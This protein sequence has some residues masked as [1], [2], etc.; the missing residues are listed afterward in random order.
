MNKKIFDILG[1]NRWHELGY[2]GKGVTVAQLELTEGIENPLNIPIYENYPSHSYK[3]WNIIKQICPEAKMLGFEDAY[4]KNTNRFEEQIY[5]YLMKND[6]QLLGASLG[7][8]SRNTDLIKV[9]KNKGMIFVNSAGNSNKDIDSIGAKYAS[10]NE[11]IDVGAVNYTPNFKKA[12]YSNFGDDL[13]IVSL[14]PVYIELRDG[15]KIPFGGTS[16]CQPIVL[17]MLALVQEFFKE[18]TGKFLNQ[19]QMLEF[20]KDNVRDLGEVGKDKYYGYGLFVLPEP[21]TIGVENMIELNI[22][23]KTAYINGKEI[24]LDIAPKIENGRTLVPL[25]FVSETLGKTVDYKDG[26]IKI[27]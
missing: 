1:I 26:N 5:P 6:V 12:S 23:S 16:A 8:N 9:L 19:D 18:K 17:G 13:E 20:I 14:V 27:H 15:R 10:S 24:E 7:G 3:T 21:D 22:G 4:N 2:T 25:R 11:W